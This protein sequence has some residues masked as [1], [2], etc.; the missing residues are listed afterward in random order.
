MG[1]KLLITGQTNSGKSSLLKDLEDVF[2]ISRDGK[3]YPFPQPHWNV[4]DFTFIEEVIYGTDDEDGHVDGIVDKINNY[5]EKFGKLP[6]TIALDSISKLLLDIEA[7]CIARISNFPYGEVNKE[8]KK[9]TDFLYELSEEFNV[10]IVSHT[11]DKGDEGELQLVNAGGAFGKKGGILSEVDF[12]LYV[13]QKGKK[14]SVHHRNYKGVTRTLIHDLPEK[15]PVTDLDKPHK[16]GDFN[17]Q[18][19]LDTIDDTHQEV[20]T[21]AM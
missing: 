13:E 8:I 21:W 2:V 20:A 6:K 7:S 18:T 16:E 10:V 15:Q 12:S 14:R 5:E 11:M 17:L 1:T 9:L 19:Y 3:K 4:P